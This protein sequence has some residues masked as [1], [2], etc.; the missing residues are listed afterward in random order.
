MWLFGSIV[1]SVLRKELRDVVREELIPL[2]LRADI[3]PQNETR[4]H[5]YY[6]VMLQLSH[7]YTPI[8]GVCPGKIP[9]V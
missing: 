4:T 1:R 9:T 6:A 7:E 2:A 8:T 5:S 3:S